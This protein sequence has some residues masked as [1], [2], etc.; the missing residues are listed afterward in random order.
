VRIRRI[1]VGVDLALSG[2]RVTFGS[3]RAV[4]QALRL[5]RH[6]GSEVV[7]VHSTWADMHE[8]DQAIRPGPSAEGRA[9]LEGLVAEATAAGLRAR[10]ALVPERVWLELIHAVQRGEGDLVIVGRHD[11]ES[12]GAAMGG[13]ARKLLRKCP[14]PVWIARPEGRAEV[15][16]IVAATDLTAVGNRAVELAAELA[17][18]SNAAL[19]VGHA[20]PL[21]VRLP[22]LPELE[23]PVET[24]LELQ[25]LES[26]ARERLEDALRSLKLPVEPH[27]HLACGAAS[28]VIRDTVSRLDADLLVMGTVSRGGI[29]GLLLGNTAERLLDRVACSLL[30]IKPRDFV[31]PVSDST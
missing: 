4:D 22:V 10:L 15:A 9:V 14:C 28:V 11:Q 31:S 20:W 21:P 19:H 2:D 23:P 12:S 24:R 18:A 16:T 6:S 26:S 29:A 5:A 13:M 3:A 30:T 25:A 7:F 17:G 8:E 27:S 1:L